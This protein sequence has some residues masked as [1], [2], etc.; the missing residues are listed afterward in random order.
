MLANLTGIQYRTTN[1]KAVSEVARLQRWKNVQIN[2]AYIFLSWSNVALFTKCLSEEISENYL[3]RK[4]GKEK[5]CLKIPNL[6][7]KVSCIG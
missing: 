2:P 6:L 4:E 5:S 7:S 3:Y 1:A